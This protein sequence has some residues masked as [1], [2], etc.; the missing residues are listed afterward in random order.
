MIN[1]ILVGNI[2]Q[3]SCDP[4][5][6]RSILNCIRERNIGDADAI[7]SCP[8]SQAFKFATLFIRF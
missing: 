4:V 1:Q 8:K 2:C 5:G 7:C 6:N 3:L